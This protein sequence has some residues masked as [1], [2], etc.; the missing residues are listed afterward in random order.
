MKLKLVY[1]KRWHF[2]CVAGRMDEMDAEEILMSS[3]LTPT[4]AMLEAYGNPKMENIAIESEGGTVY[5]VGGFSKDGVVWF[6]VTKEVSGFSLRDKLQLFRLI[7]LMKDKVLTNVSPIIYN[8]VYK[9]NTQ[10]L[11]LLELLGADFEEVPTDDRF[12]LFSIEHPLI[13]EVPIV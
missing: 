3:G 1:A 5:A 8:T 9:K 11:K 7:E 2:S 13:K 4:A 6:V 12:L 10:H